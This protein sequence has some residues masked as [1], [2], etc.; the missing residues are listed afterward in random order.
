MADDPRAKL[1]L[2]Q[3]RLL[4]WWEGKG[5]AVWI[6]APAD[7]PWLEIEPP[8]IPLDMVAR[9][10]DPAFRVRRSLHGLSRTYF[11]GAAFPYLDTM[12]GPGSLGL[13]LG[14]EP[15][16]DENTVW[17]NPCIADP[18]ATPP[19]RFDP[20]NRWWK[21]H[22][23]LIEE[24]AAQAV[25]LGSPAAASLSANAGRPTDV[26]QASS[27][28]DP[29]EAAQ[30]GSL[31]YTPIPVG[32]PDLIENWDTLAQLRDPM[33]LLMDSLDRP[34]W[35]LAQ[36]DAINE[37]FFQAFDLIYDLIKLPN[38]QS[39]IQ[40]PK[41]GCVFAAFSLW[42]PGKTAKVQCDAASMLAPE[43]FKRFV[44]PALT[45]QCEWL[46]YSM[47]HLDG[48]TCFPILDALLE[49]EPLKAVEFT[50]QPQLPG[51]GSPEWYGLYRR[52]RSA[53]KSVQA[54]WVKPDEVLPLLDALGPEGMY[55][56]VE[57]REEQE[58]RKLEREVYGD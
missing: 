16:F 46:D 9:W 18:D 53:G 40:N 21:A 34:D 44:R 19:V 47:F 57:C 15:G 24:A 39:E 22:L 20:E 56:M 12:I 41:S 6:T 38:P 1:P 10:T 11:G 37:A 23:A 28:C 49:I 26:A 30:A 25:S 3:R 2:A 29:K 55:V 4:N 43:H 31:R 58:A 52:I 5:C 8:A 42:G 35:V 51:G 32:M 27:L 45:R 50:P 48:T 7:E 33:A 36:I 13:F 14:S 54:I 17:Y